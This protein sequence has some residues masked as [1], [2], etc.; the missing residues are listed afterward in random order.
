MTVLASSSCAFAASTCTSCCACAIGDALH[1]SPETH[2]IQ[3]GRCRALP[4][5][6]QAPGQQIKSRHL[7]FR[8]ATPPAVWTLIP[9]HYLLQNHSHRECRQDMRA[10]NPRK[11]TFFTFSMSAPM[12]PKGLPPPCRAASA[13]APHSL[14]SQ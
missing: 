2:D 8:A 9:P 3:P 6:Q 4:H 11:R 14:A 1:S 5:R 10:E 12:S 13:T 7:N